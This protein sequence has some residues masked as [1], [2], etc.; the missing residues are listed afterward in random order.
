MEWFA[1]SRGLPFTFAVEVV[2]SPLLAAAVV[3]T[4]VDTAVTVSSH[5]V[6]VASLQ[7]CRVGCLTLRDSTAD[8]R[9]RS[10]DRRLLGPLL[11]D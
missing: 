9:F 5:C 11:W 6:A 4:V 8:G 10:S 2:L 1:S 3:V 7:A